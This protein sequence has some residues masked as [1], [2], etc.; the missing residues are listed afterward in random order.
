M[1]T[2]SHFR[3]KF[4]RVCLAS[5]YVVGL[6]VLYTFVVELLKDVTELLFKLGVPDTFLLVLAY[7]FTGQTAA[8]HLSLD[9]T[10]FFLCDLIHSG[11]IFLFLDATC[12]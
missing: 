1:P 4:S 9:H 2:L 7:V 10:F 5:V 8:V 6:V 11:V 12:R 3:I